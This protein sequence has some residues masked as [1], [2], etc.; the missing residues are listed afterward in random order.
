MSYFNKTSLLIPSQLP[1]YIR[2]DP[3]YS[4]FVDFIQA[5]YEW[6]EQQGGFVYESKNLKKYYDVDTTLNEFI[7]YYINEFMPLFPTESLA[8]KRKL[9]KLIREVYQTKGTPASYKFLFRTLYNSEAET[10]NAKDF[11]LRAS[12]GKWIVTK[13]ITINDTNPVWLQS[14]GYRLFGL[15]SKGYATIEN[16]I[17]NDSSINVILTGIERNFSAGEFV[18]VVDNKFSPVSFP[19]GTLTAQS[20]GVI[21]SVTP[22][23]NNKGENYDVGD[24]VVFY[25]G[26]NPE[27][28]N[29]VGA[30]AYVSEVS[31]ASV[32]GIDAVYP[33]EGYRP[34]GFTTVTISSTS[35]AGNGASAIVTDTNFDKSSPYYV[36]YVATDILDTKWDIQLNSGNYDFANLANANANTQLSI[37]FTHPVLNTYGISQSTLISGGSGYDATAFA[38]A[39]GFFA[40]EI[41]DHSVDQPLE[42]LPSLGILAPIKIEDGGLGYSTGDVIQ[43]IGGRG[44]GATANIT[45]VA[46]NGLI[47]SIDYVAHPSGIYPPGGMGYTIELMPEISVTSANGFG[48]ILSFPGLI[49]GDAVFGLTETPYGQVRKITITNPGR[50]YISAPK[51]SL[52]VTD[53]L[54]YN[55]DINNLPLKG[56]ISYQ[57]A[58]A[59]IS[60]TANLDSV[61][62]ISTNANTLLSQYNLRI[63]NYDG[64]FDSNSVIKLTREGVDIGA[65]IVV[66]NVT[67]GIYSNGIKQ[68]G[69]GSAKAT[70]KF[71]NGVIATDGIYVNYDGQPSAYSLLQ[72]EDYNNYTYILQVQKEL[73]RYKD[74]AIKFLHPAGLKYR[75]VD[76]LKS[77]NNFTMNTSADI[78]TIQD[79]GY[80]LGVND[81][82]ATIPNNSNTI[83]LT[84]LSGA[85]VANVVNVNSYVTYNTRYNHPFYSKITSVSSNTISLEDNFIT[86]VPNVA[87]ANASA[88]S[89]T[90]NI[91]SLTNAWNVAT[92]NIVSHISNFINNYDYISFDGGLTYKTVTHVDL[93][94]GGN[95]ILVNSA[96]ASAQTGYLMLSKNVRTSDIYVSGYVSEIETISL[97]TEDEIP[98][99]TEDERILILG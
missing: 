19:T 20:Y 24:P 45:S 69:N 18:K 52:R 81:F 93:P 76:I 29:P 42:S 48:A 41:G 53:L 43:I 21:T 50:D 28:Q 4:N 37:A 2:D 1:E 92:G 59:T 58:N 15:S 82:I 62:I 23:S 68:Y 56:D 90:I 7:N 6:A 8:D 79:L 32:T 16:I 5:Y 98:L 44:F 86:T 36:N 65:N 38:N 89:N 26:L 70:V 9:L 78:I 27:T 64:T 11:V 57:T 35:G 34:A 74:T 46:A 71:T 61:S 67:T 66:A 3:S 75:S 80:L 17:I 94:D 10:Y 99:T 30:S 54:V 73:A 22:D 40:T 49:G 85:N 77:T 84:N 95:T 51:A 83:I 25:G 39:T 63:Y 96:Y 47:Q 88:N 91:T 60:F 33:G 13:Y 97:L 72:N 87:V 14:I 12:D 31:F 55:V